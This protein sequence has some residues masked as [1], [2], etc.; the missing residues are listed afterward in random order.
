MEF[1]DISL[2]IDGETV[3]YPGNP[4]PEI[5]RYRKIPE[6]STTESEVR[7]GSHTGTHVDAPEHVIE[8]GESAENLEIEE[9]YGEAQV[10]DLT[11]CGEKVDRSDLEDKT[12]K[13][14]IVL[15][16]TENSEKGYEEFRRDFTYLTL[17][18]V[19]YMVQQEV[20]TVAIDY[21]SLTKFNG[22]ERDHRAHRV[23]NREMN[24]IE[25]VDLEGIEPGIYTFIGMPLKIKAD[26]AP[27]R[28]VLLDEG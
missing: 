19:R 9:F 27:L 26:G 3:T 24:V 5:E 12:I 1:I 6:D 14:D 25:G 22:S 4:E 17:E 21:L 20:S 28:A 15:V 18:A 10:L 13:K 16:K 8:D 2:R 23:A 7:I 11:G